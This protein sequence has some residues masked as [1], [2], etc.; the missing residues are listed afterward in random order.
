[1][2]VDGKAAWD[3]KYEAIEEK[4]LAEDATSRYHSLYNTMTDAEKVLYDN[5]IIA[6]IKGRVAKM[7]E[8]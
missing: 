2:T 3:K 1:M 6:Q 5:I 7:D 8:A 4:L